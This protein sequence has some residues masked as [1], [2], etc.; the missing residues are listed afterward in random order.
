MVKTLNK[1]RAL[2]ITR[3]VMHLAACGQD[4]QQVKCRRVTSQLVTNANRVVWIIPKVLTTSELKNCKPVTPVANF[5][6]ALQYTFDRAT[7]ALEGPLTQPPAGIQALMRN[8]NSVIH[9]GLL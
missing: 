4:Q 9:E 5:K 1:L 8:A 6:I 2:F 3:R 7:V